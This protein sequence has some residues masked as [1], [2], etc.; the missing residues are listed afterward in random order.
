[1]TEATTKNM[2]PRHRSSK[3]NTPSASSRSNII[4][5]REEST[6]KKG[7]SGWIALAFLAGGVHGTVY[8]AATPDAAVAS[9]S[10][11]EIPNT[12]ASKSAGGDQLEEI[13][14]TATKHEENLSKVPISIVA[15]TQEAMQASGVKSIE[16]IAA[17]VPGLTL[18]SSNGAP[19]TNI[20]I[21]GIST[22]YGDSTTGV[23]IDD[24]PI[25]ARVSNTSEFGYPLP[26][27]FDVDRV[28]VAR[29]PQGTLF[30]AGA[31]GGTVRFVMTEPSLVDS[32]GF[33]HAELAGTDGGGL[34]YEVG[35]AGGGP[36]IDN[37]L[38]FRASVW[39]RR[40][41][42]YVDRVD[43]ITGA[44]VE[45]NA[46][47]SD[48]RSARLALK[49]AV[50]DSVSI[51]PSIYYQSTPTNDTSLLWLYLSSVPDGH[52]N[53]G[54][55]VRQPLSD[56]F[57]VD[58]L[59]ID[60]NLGPLS[61][62]A[63]TSY[64]NRKSSENLD[65]TAFIGAL[66]LPGPDGWGDPRGPAYPTSY[67][68]LVTQLTSTDQGTISQEIRVS[69]SDPKAPI[70]WVGGLFYS[71]SRQDDKSLLIGASVDSPADDS[72]YSD[73]TISIDTQYALFGQAD[74]KLGDHWKLTGGLRASSTR[75]NVEQITSGALEAGTPPVFIGNQKETPVTP[76]VAL[77]YQVNE[78]TL[79]YLSAAKGYRIGGVN[80]PIPTYC[81]D[82]SAPPTFK[83]DSV[84]SYEIGAKSLLFDRH[85]QIDASAFH[86]KW[87]NIQTPAFLA[88]CGFQYVANDGSATSNGFD[89]ALRALLTDRLRIGVSAGYMN[90]RFDQTIISDGVPIVERGDAV[91][92]LPQV[93]SPWNVTT[94]VEY[95]FP[96]TDDAR[97]YGRAED[98]F[99][100]RNPGPFAT[101]QPGYSYAPLLTA[102]PS[103]NVVNLRAGIRWPRYDVS[104]FVNNVTD[105]L[106][107][108]YRTQ[109]TPTS[110]LFYGKTFRPRTVGVTGNWKF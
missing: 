101:Q 63:V 70:T 84:W 78:D 93:P 23:Y 72:I 28:E 59:K 74:F 99:H 43:P 14:V 98:V 103:T 18:D 56:T 27:T 77:S 86:I 4:R 7:L 90:A 22:T 11:A 29:G 104:L 107:I 2:N 49:F 6:R 100:S 5:S 75:F 68:D 81:G 39:D 87:Q 102:N 55:L 106:P 108:L 54:S 96:L 66:G 42:G 17:L 21:R 52:L 45:P 65:F 60:A 83:S 94:N 47:W 40:D 25:Q 105:S 41:G 10:S 67:S 80:S 58:T 89:A 109:D 36:L 97:L 95:E 46:N 31:E 8:A 69:S 73:Q 76:K 53:N 82:V 3:A 24:T 13:L 85:L 16:D 30:G 51:T 20:A 15:M 35:A 61:L 48:K 19:N 9:E 38:G 92:L 26:V 34:S 71:R 1:M 33:T 88:E 110:T 79:L 37:L 62:T 64:F 44:I 91:G 12:G 57:Y 32:G 50:S